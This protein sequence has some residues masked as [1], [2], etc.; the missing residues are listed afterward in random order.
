MFVDAPGA[1]PA[2]R[3]A[4]AL[5][6]ARRAER[7]LPYHLAYLAEACRIAAWLRAV[8]RR[9]TC[10]RTSA[11]TRPRSRCWRTRSAAPRVQLHR[12][13]AGGVRR[14]ALP[15]PRREGAPLRRSWSRSAR[16]GRSQLYRWVEHAHWP[17]CRSC[18]AGWSASVPRRRAGAAAG[19]AA[20]WS[21]SAG[22]A[23]RR[24]SCCWSRRLRAWRRTGVALRAGAGRRRRAAGRARSR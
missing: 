11:P 24:A 15:R 4:L 12:A 5:R 13:R 8:R 3:S 17:K 1:L 16:Y 21:A 2:R 10:T 19:G 14:A 6:M 7:P 22:C 18:I 23:S 20:R 9:V